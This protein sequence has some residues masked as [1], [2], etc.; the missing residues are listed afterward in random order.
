MKTAPYIASDQYPQPQS[1]SYVRTWQATEIEFGQDLGAHL[2]E[3]DQPGN[4]LVQPFGGS[5][6]CVSMHRS[7]PPLC[8]RSRRSLFAARLSSPDAF[9]RT[10]ICPKRCDVLP[11]VAQSLA[12]VA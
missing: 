6:R 4:A 8:A 3:Y 1:P 9:H 2:P 5:P 12:L 7:I 11:L 10:Q